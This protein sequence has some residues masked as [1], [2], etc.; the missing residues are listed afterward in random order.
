MG[1]TDGKIAGGICMSEAMTE[2]EAARELI[3]R[4]AMA[5]DTEDF[6]AWVKLFDENGL[7]ELTAYSSEIRRWMTWQSSD[8]ATLDKLLKEVDEHVRDT[9]KRRHIVGMPLVEITGDQGH[10][11]SNFSLFRTLPDGQ[12]SLYMVGQYDDHIVK[13]SGAWLYAVHK[14]ITDTRVLESFTHVPI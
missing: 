4:T 10:V 12:S 5:L 13:R 3:Q 6:D 14:V 1:E 9:A 7:Y 11:R 2:R 8:K